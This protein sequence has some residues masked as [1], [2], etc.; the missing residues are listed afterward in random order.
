MKTVQVA[1]VTG[2]ALAILIPVL[3]YRPANVVLL[4]SEVMKNKG[5]GEHLRQ[6]LI[7]HCNLKESD[8]RVVEGLPDHNYD[9]I[10]D[11]IMNLSDDLNDE[12][13]PKN[14]TYNI[15]GGN[16]LMAAAV[17]EVIEGEPCRAIYNDTANN[18]IEFIRPGSDRKVEPMKTLLTIESSLAATHKTLRKHALDDWEQ[19]ALSRKALTFW[20]ANN[21]RPKSLEEG[22]DS[23]LQHFLGVINREARAPLDEINNKRNVKPSGLT[24]KLNQ[25]PRGGWFYDF[26]RLSGDKLINWS[27]EKPDYVCFQDESSLRYFGG[28]GWMEEYAWLVGKEAGCDE[29]LANVEVTD[30]IKKSANVRNELDVILRKGNRIVIVEC[31][32]GK[33]GS[34]ANKDQ[35]MIYKLDSIGKQIGL[36][37]EKVLLSSRRLDRDAGKFKVHNSERAKSHEIIAF[38]ADKLPEFENW[39]KL[40]VEGKLYPVS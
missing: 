39:V 30:D 34:D 14:I 28:G 24:V 16:K 4:L 22:K 38:D 35:N 1:I 18:Q 11:Y 21:V 7:K 8:V 2:Q 12:F 33:M 36:F 26:K 29:V 10:V 37:T 3:Q 6:L 23:P 15:T 5:E 25:A 17:L 9:S 19:A 20:L 40:W 31:K 13:E 27:D 32:T